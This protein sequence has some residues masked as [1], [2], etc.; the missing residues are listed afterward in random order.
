MDMQEFKLRRNSLISKWGEKLVTPT[1][2][3][4]AQQMKDVEPLCKFAKVRPEK[5]LNAM[6]QTWLRVGH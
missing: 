2:E 5:I 4:L 3:E 6:A 1:P